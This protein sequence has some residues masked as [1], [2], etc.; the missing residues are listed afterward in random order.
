M[1]DAPSP[2]ILDR[3]L[4]RLSRVW[5]EA[6]RPGRAPGANAPHPDLPDAALGHLREQIDACL[7]GRG[8]EVS[9]RSQAAELGELYLGLNETGRGRFLGLLASDYGVDRSALDAALE[10]LQGASGEADRLTAQGRLRDALVAPRVRLMTQF[11]ALPEGVKFLVDLRDD[12]LRMANQAPALRAVEQD[13][14]QLL[15]SWFDVGFLELRRITWNAPAAQLEKLIAYEAVHE[16]RSWDDLKNRLDS[17]RRCYAFFHP[18]MP[19]E[20]LIFIEV[21]LVTGMA[22]NIQALLDEDAPADDPHKADTAIFY[23]ISNAQK[24]LVGVNFG[25]FLIKRVVDDLAR[26]F[27]GIRAFATLSPVPGFRGW[28]DARLAARDGMLLTPAEDEALAALTAEADGASALTALLARPTWPSEPDTV[29][30][31]RAPLTR[32]CAQYLLHAK[33][34]LRALD[35]VA[36]FHLSNGARVERINWLANRSAN[37]IAQSAGTMVNYLYKLGDIETNH[38]NYRGDGLISASAEVRN[39]LKT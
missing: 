27:P 6:V 2:S 23:S 24:G 21:A 12:L 26:D 30:A 34:G 7:A 19:D 5:R 33:S 9:A 35:P 10:A 13:L 31:V 14:K 22:S 20:P 28:L 37:G 29:K 11:N 3:T 36:N 17:D 25:G 4:S 39:L 18:R 1:N 15:I 38:E 16:I 32:A 8:G